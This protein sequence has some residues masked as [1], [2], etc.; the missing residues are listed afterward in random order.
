MDPLG[1][2]PCVAK[3]NCFRLW[4][5]QHACK[6]RLTNSN[7]PR[8]SSITSKTH[9]AKRPPQ[10]PSI[11]PAPYVKPVLYATEEL[12]FVSSQQT[13]IYLIAQSKRIDPS[14]IAKARANLTWC[15]D[16]ESSG[17]ATTTQDDSIIWF[18]S[19]TK[20]PPSKCFLDTPSYSD[21]LYAVVN[22][23]GCQ[24]YT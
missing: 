15:K 12:A 8:C 11:L 14:C 5:Q 1:L 22:E 3:Q 4:K 23:Y 16:I 7:P 18:A 6:L 19:S 13:G 20:L 24:I 17:N 2:G 21:Y 10:S 9:S